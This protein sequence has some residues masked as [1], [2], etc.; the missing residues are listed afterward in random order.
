MEDK[1]RFSKMTP[2]RVTAEEKKQI[3]DL[4]EKLG[5]KYYLMAFERKQRQ[6][7]DLEI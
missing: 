4:E 6:K 1:N 5:N 3:R 7:F 2:A